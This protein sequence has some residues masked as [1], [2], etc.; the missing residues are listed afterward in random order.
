MTT[1]HHIVITFGNSFSATLCRIL[2]TNQSQNIQVY[3][4]HVCTLPC[5]ILLWS[6][7][8]RAI[9]IFP[10]IFRVNL[11]QLV[12]T[13][14]APMAPIQLG[15]CSLDCQFPVILILSILTGQD[16]TLCT[17]K[18]LVAQYSTHLPQLPKTFQPS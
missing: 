10:T 14:A 1:S 6:F 3:H 18:V 11:G 16:E 2:A 4:K 5:A 17:H 12:A 9:T 15:S 8:K 7:K 13:V